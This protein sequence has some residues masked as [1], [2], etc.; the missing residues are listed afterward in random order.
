MG[1][2]KKRSLLHSLGFAVILTLTVYVILE[3]EYPRVGLIRVDAMDQILAD[4]RQSMR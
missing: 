2:L 3:L 1:G 4:V